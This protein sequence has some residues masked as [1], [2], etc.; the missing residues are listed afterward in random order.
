[1][2]VRR[3]VSN[4]SDGPLGRQAEF[5]QDREILSQAAF[6]RVISIER[7]R[8]ERSRKPFLLMLA[9]HGRPPVIGNQRQEC[10]QAPTAL[11]VSTQGDRR[12]RLV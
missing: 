11:A 6:H 2:N 10:K 1:M 9:G 8:T 4:L 7:R 12:S 3:A 5:A